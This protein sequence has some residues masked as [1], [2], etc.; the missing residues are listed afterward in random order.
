MSQRVQTYQRHRLALTASNRGLRLLLMLLTTTSPSVL[1]HMGLGISERA[2]SISQDKSLLIALCHPLI[3]W[4]QQSLYV[5]PCRL[6]VL[7][8]LLITVLA[9]QWSRMLPCILQ[10]AAAQSST[11]GLSPLIAVAE[12]CCTLAQSWVTAALAAVVGPDIGPMWSDAAACTGLS[13]LQTLTTFGILC[14]LVL[15]PVLAVFWFDA[16]LRSLPRASSQSSSSSSS[17]RTTH[18]P[19]SDSESQPPSSS[20]VFA[21]AFAAVDLQALATS[22]A[23]KSG[24]SSLYLV[25]LSPVILG[26]TFIVA[27]WL[28]REFAASTSCPAVLQSAG[29]L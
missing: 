22:A 18:A 8:Q 20:Y 3:F 26:L 1:G 23:A 24:V 12:S 5:L 25:L 15:L 6:T 29:L 11:D 19:D 7:T 10:H 17:G 28:T 21:Q 13:A 27:E 2:L 16:W 4:S 9:L 14:V